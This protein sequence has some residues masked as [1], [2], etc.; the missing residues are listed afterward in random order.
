M[1][2]RLLQSRRDRKSS[3]RRSATFGPVVAGFLV[4]MLVGEVAI[5]DKGISAI[6]AAVRDPASL[7]SERSPGVRAPGA[8][9]Q[10]KPGHVP[11]AYSAFADPA[12][13]PVP[14]AA[15]TSEPEPSAFAA[16]TPE[17][18]AD[19]IPVPGP[20]SEAVPPAGIPGPFFNP[21]ANPFIPPVGI[22]GGGGG[23]NDPDPDPTPPTTT[24][25]VTPPTGAVPEPATWAMLVLGF[26][27]VGSIMRRQR[28]IQSAALASGA[29]AR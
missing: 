25:P 7:F 4:V 8:K 2:I 19:T 10:T 14:P 5:G 21:P 22:P 11:S 28:R 6:A 23:G 17:T 9:F 24:P 18:P 15:G 20:F 13:T 12:R 16:M 27:S 26:F 29:I 1:K 3:K